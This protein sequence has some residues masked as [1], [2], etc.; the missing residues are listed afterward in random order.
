MYTVSKFLHFIVD[1]EYTILFNLKNE[2]FFVLKKDLAQRV[3]E[4]KER[5]DALEVIHPNLF[6]QMKENGMIVLS[7]E[8]EVEQLIEMWRKQDNSPAHFSMI[9]NPTL[10]CNL[11]CWYCYENHDKMPM[12]SADMVKAIQK[13]IK[14]KIENP[15][16]KSLNVS[17]FGGEPLLGF[18]AVVRP[19]L[20][21]ASDL[22]K[23][24][25][26]TLTS[27]FTTNGTLLND[28]VLDFLE[29]IHISHSTTFQISLDGN[30]ERH[31]CTRIGTNRLPTYDVIIK[32]IKRTAL[33]E[34]NV[35]VRLNYTID[36][37]LSFV[38]VLEDFRDF[39]E[40][41]KKFLG[42][43]FQQIWQD[44]ER[45]PHPHSRVE[46]V[47]STFKEEGFNVDMDKIYHRFCCYAD[48]ENNVVINYD[49]GLFK[50]TARD[51]TIEN[52]EGLLSADGNLEW[53]ERFYKRMCIKYANP[54]CLN[55]KILPLCNGGCSQG[56]L[57]SGDKGT[58]FR[59]LD[60]EAKNDIIIKRLEQLIEKNK[61]SV[62]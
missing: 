53:N 25:G 29:S 10:N 43:N 28:D 7:G 22:C 6:Q 61:K 21:Y 38:D 33:R 55:C 44:Q 58:C 47:M 45:N 60:E 15:E 20:D 59:H 41:A 13:L 40:E 1:G 23:S 2:S 27:G 34:S 26:I 30:R 32:N 56:K 9:I 24:K 37:I 62:E 50:C 19:L 46:D 39:P 35:S 57:E 52:R 48:R 17:F 18:K 11:R 3:N 54:A 5:I 31:D 8:N 36:N 12:M 14:R 4:C 49:G 42:F 16:H 51:F